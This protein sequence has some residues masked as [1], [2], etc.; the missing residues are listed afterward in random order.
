M[1]DKQRKRGR[2]KG[3]AKTAL[4]KRNIWN[5]LTIIGGWVA[6]TATATVSRFLHPLVWTS[7]LSWPSSACYV[8]DS[9]LMII[10]GFDN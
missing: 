5:L 9:I 3:A 4:K 1:H 8:N 7:S 6:T 10:F 2:L